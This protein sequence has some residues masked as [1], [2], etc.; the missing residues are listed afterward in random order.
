MKKYFAKKPCRFADKDYYIGEEIPADAV[1]PERE[2]A[3]VKYGTISVVDAAD[4]E[5]HQTP[6]EPPQVPA[7]EGTTNEPPAD[8]EPPQ[9]PPADTETDKGNG[10]KAQQ[11]KKVN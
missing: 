10:K 9:T 7:G 4:P 6:A 11:G 8:L 1:L 5:A 3:L 2:N